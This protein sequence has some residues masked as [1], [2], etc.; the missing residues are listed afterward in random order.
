MWV[1]V[2]RGDRKPLKRFPE[3]GRSGAA[4]THMNVG[5][6]ENYTSPGAAVSRSFPMKCQAANRRRRKKEKRR[7]AVTGAEKGNFNQWP[8]KPIQQP[9]FPSYCM[10]PYRQFPILIVQS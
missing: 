1:K 9:G 3:L 7:V 4:L 6:N 8:L 10:R 2:T 5:V